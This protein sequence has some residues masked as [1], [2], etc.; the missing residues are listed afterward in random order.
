[1]RDSC[2]V[3]TFH[4][5]P[6]KELRQSNAEFFCPNSFVRFEWVQDANV[7]SI[8]EVETLFGPRPKAV[9]K[10][11]QSRRWCVPANASNLAKRLEVRSFSAALCRVDFY[12]W[13]MLFA[14]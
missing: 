11:A 10:H 5:L 8:L 14:V 13:M 2:V 7:R 9:L 4:E 6:T 1:M 12:S 3:E